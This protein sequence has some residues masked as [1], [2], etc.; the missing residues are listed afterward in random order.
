[1]H[2]PQPQATAAKWKEAIAA[3]SS[4]AKTRLFK[5]FY[6]CGGD[7]VEMEATMKVWSTTETKNKEEEGWV[8]R[9]QLAWH[10]HCPENSTLINTIIDR[11]RLLLNVIF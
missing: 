5:E 2:T 4:A 8:T 6:E 10:Y 1:V 11:K 3:N 7:L 9:G